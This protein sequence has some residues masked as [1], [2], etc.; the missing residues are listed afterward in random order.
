MSFKTIF[1]LCALLVAMGGLNSC[2]FIKDLTT[3]RPKEEEARTST[4]PERFPEPER[5]PQPERFPEPERSPVPGYDEGAVLRRDIAD[6][7]RRFVG[8]IY[9]YA[10]RTPESGFDCSGFT[11]YVL[12]QF[13]IILSPSSRDQARQGQEIP[14]DQA[15]PGDLVFYRR[16]SSEAV[17]HVSLV[18]ENRGDQ[19]W[20]AHSTTSRGVLVEDVLASKYWKP[21]LYMARDVMGRR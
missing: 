20:V 12:G 9:V 19:L 7:A 13:G 18:V 4:Q 2:A 10:G 1:R 15:Q 17:F 3:D 8:T 5:P 6:Y 14:I 11:G 16:S 21:Y